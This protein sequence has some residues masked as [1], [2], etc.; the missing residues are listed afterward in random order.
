MDTTPI[1]PQNTTLADGDGTENPTTDNREQLTTELMASMN[2]DGHVTPS[3]SIMF[4]GTPK[5]KKLSNGTLRF[6]ADMQYLFPDEELD[7]S[8]DAERQ[9]TSPEVIRLFNVYGKGRDAQRRFEPELYIVGKLTDA[10]EIQLSDHPALMKN[11]NTA[12]VAVDRMTKRFGG[13]YMF[14]ALSRAFSGVL[15]RRLCLSDDIGLAKIKVF[16]RPNPKVK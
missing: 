5:P 6:I 2:F 13:T 11:A 12:Q 16:V 10:G 15:K 3:R 1:T 14:F 8:V 4:S 9:F 7:F